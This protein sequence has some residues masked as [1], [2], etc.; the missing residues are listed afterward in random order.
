VKGVEGGW[1]ECEVSTVEWRGQNPETTTGKW[2]L[3][4]SGQDKEVAELIYDP[5]RNNP[6]PPF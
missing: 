4:L 2:G 1:T 3:N 5:D 6:W